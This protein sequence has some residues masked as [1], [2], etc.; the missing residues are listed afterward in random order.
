MIR[1][2]AAKV[3]AGDKIVVF[4]PDKF[5]HVCEVGSKL[6]QG[7]FSPEGSTMLLF[8][9][10]SK[11][12]HM[13]WN[14]S[15]PEEH[16]IRVV[17]KESDG[18]KYCVLAIGQGGYRNKYWK[19]GDPSWT[20]N[21]AEAAVFDTAQYAAW[22]ARRVFPHPPSPGRKTYYDVVP[23]SWIDGDE[24]TPDEPVAEEKPEHGDDY[25]GLPKASAVVIRV[26]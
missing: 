9:V 11:S 5:W 14:M 12:T 25:D 3:N 8:L 24:D 17:N 1:K 7:I 16:A 23:F 15:C 10:Q 18:V 2:S 13:L 20:D 6:S 22:K 21:K 4:G 26:P 19:E